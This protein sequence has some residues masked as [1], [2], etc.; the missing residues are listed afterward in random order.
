[1]CTLIRNKCSFSVPA[2]VTTGSLPQLANTILQ[3]NQQSSNLSGISTAFRLYLSTDKLHQKIFVI[4]RKSAFVECLALLTLLQAAPTG[5]PPGQ[6]GRW[7]LCSCRCQSFRRTGQ[8]RPRVALK[9]QKMPNF[10]LQI[11]RIIFHLGWS[12]IRPPDNQDPSST[13][14]RT[15]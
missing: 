13:P 14:G 6:S 5:T 4:T 1:M 7:T 10:V 3:P 15:D 8:R 2:I 12:E 11:G 9:G